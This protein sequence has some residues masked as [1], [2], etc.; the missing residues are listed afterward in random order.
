MNKKNK[1]LI[2]SGIIIIIILTAIAAVSIIKNQKNDGKDNVVLSNVDVTKRELIN[3]FLQRNPYISSIEDFEEGLIS[4]TDIVKSAIYS[5]DI[6]Q[7][8]IVD[9]DIMKNVLLVDFEAY[10]KPI[11]S[12]KQYSKEIFGQENLELNFVET[13]YNDSGYLIINDDYVFFSKQEKKEKVYIAVGQRQ[14]GE[15]LELQIYE[16]NVTEEN[17]ESLT[18]ML[19]TGEINK[20]I[21]IS[22]RYILT[23]QI[24][25]ENIKITGKTTLSN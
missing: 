15:L 14:Q 25:G 24:E 5:D 13:Y 2:I 16:Y 9:E 23:G 19:E 12:I 11:E 20:E 10:K 8:F 6:E 4:D 22:N 21:S 3:D 7:E 1:L 17:R 18:K